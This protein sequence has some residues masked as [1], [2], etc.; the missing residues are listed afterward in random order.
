MGDEMR[1]AL[2]KQ[3]AVAK[4]SKPS[5]NTES[6]PGR[7]T[8]AVH[9]E[10][11]VSNG[12]KFQE[13]SDKATIIQKPLAVQQDVSITP[14][15]CHEFISWFINFYLIFGYLVLFL[16]YC[17]SVWTTLQDLKLQRGGSMRDTNKP[18]MVRLSSL[19]IASV[20]LDFLRFLF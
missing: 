17:R 13:K 12:T 14:K 5:S 2:K 15:L 19:E 8:K 16:N 1:P 11:K 18:R 4:P 7:P 20:V 9:V 3:G 6:G 10:R